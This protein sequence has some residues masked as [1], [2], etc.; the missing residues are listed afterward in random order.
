MTQKSQIKTHQESLAA[1]AIAEEAEKQ[2]VK[3]EARERVLRDFERGLGLGTLRS[4]TTTT[5]KDTKSV[6]SSLNGEAEE[7]GTKRKFEFDQDAVERAT[8]DAEI[9][10]L[11]TIEAEQV[12]DRF[13]LKGIP[14]KPEPDD[15][16]PGFSW[17]LV[18]HVSG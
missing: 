16:P 6:E 15:K 7:R 17:C 18:W 12:S 5:S 3:A 9:A 1:F 8:R 11:K 2:R 4:T 14:K 13:F 10:A